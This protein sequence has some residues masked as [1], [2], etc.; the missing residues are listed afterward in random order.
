M[1]SSPTAE[2]LSILLDDFN[3]YAAT[4]K[5]DEYFE[6][7]HSSG[8]FL[9]TDATEN[10]IKSEFMEFSRPHFQGVTAW[11]YIPKS[12][13]RI[14]T[15]VSH[16]DSTIATFDEPLFCPKLDCYARGS[17]SAIW[18]N[19][20]LRWQLLIYHLSFAIPND[21]AVNVNRTIMSYFN[22]QDNLNKEMNANAN[23]EAL[24]KELEQEES[25]ILNS[26]IQK[27]KSKNKKK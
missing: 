13:N 4:A 20:K 18:D 12:E 19:D 5:F 25:Q 22:Q 3:Q 7:F 24:L 16:G 27:K 2:S 1:S 23:A 11:T 8:R 26:T 10:W 21:I 6:C 15:L 14:I 17:G 9:G